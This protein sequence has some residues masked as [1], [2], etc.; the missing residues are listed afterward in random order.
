MQTKPLLDASKG[1]NKL[2]MNRSCCEMEKSKLVS[3]TRAFVGNPG[4]V[5]CLAILLV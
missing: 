3:R 4:F 1:H 5:G 2:H